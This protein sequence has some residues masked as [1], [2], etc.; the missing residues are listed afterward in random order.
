LDLSIHR[1]NNHLYLGIYRKPTQTD[2]TTHFTCNHPLH[3][4]GPWHCK[5]TCPA[6]NCLTVKLCFGLPCHL[7]KFGHGVF[8]HSIFVKVQVIKP[9]LHLWTVSFYF[10]NKP[11]DGYILAKTCS[12]LCLINVS[13]VWT[14]YVILLVILS[15]GCLFHIVILQLFNYGPLWKCIC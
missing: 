13:C 14:E 6:Y 9:P 11:S 10:C 3:F 8:L 12:W 15:W 7:T 2:T 4:D 5:D 1:H